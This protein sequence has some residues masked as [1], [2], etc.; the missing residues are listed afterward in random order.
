MSV[1][2]GAHNEALCEKL[3]LEGEWYDWIVTIAFYAALHYVE[4]RIFPL[5]IKDITYEKFD[6][7]YPSRTD[8]TK[9]QHEA[10][11]KLVKERLNMGYPA[12]RFLYDSSRNARY[13]NYKV[14][15]ELAKTAMLKLA[16]VK[17]L[18]IKSSEQK[19][20]S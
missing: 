18:C 12:Y 20:L 15:H 4:Y 7:Y 19:K 14:S 6:N 17:S 2:Q 11:L 13:N 3:S 9:S 1:E 8:N 10:R 5:T 16:V